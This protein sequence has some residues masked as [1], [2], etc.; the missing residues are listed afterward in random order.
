MVEENKEKDLQETETKVE[1]ETTEAEFV[2]TPKA[3]IAED[4]EYNDSHLAE[5]NVGVDAET[6]SKALESSDCLVTTAEMRGIKT[7][8]SSDETVEQ[9]KETPKKKTAKKSTGSN[10]SKSTKAKAD[11]DDKPKSESK[12]K[13]RKMNPAIVK[14]V[15]TL[16]EEIKLY[17]AKDT[18][19][20][21]QEDTKKLLNN[22]STNPDHYELENI[23]GYTVEQCIKHCLTPLKAISSSRTITIDVLRTKWKQFMIQFSL[24]K[25]V[26]GV[27]VL[28]GLKHPQAK[29]VIEQG[30]V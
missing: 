17:T 18:V 2:Q 23:G 14:R 12:P 1:T 11:S 26:D 13:H 6:L 24:F 5:E 25:T 3:E 10:K 7:T 22:F 15:E 4:L 20:T 19:P 28:Q 21:I 30:K 27:T 29:K 16:N 9:P 8:P